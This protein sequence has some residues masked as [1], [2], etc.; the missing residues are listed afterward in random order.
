[1]GCVGLNTATIVV[2]NV[3][4]LIRESK[5]MFYLTATDMNAGTDCPAE[6]QELA[7]FDL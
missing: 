5:I 1:M 4:T 2:A 6:N 7:G 3:S